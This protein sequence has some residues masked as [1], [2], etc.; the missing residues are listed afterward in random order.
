MAETLSLAFH[1]K[2]TSA[3]R[4]RDGTIDPKS[5]WLEYRTGSSDGSKGWV[6]TVTGKIAQTDR[7]VQPIYT[8]KIQVVSIDGVHK[9]SK[10]VMIRMN[11]RTLPE[12]LK[13]TLRVPGYIP[14]RKTAFTGKFSIKAI[15]LPTLP[16]KPL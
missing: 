15:E 2:H 5:H 14:N 10:N 12:V 4:L 13:V 16:Q 7:V 3:W 11:M 8:Y 9:A 6:L 1:T